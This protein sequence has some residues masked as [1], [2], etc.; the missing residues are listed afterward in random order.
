MLICA[1]KKFVCKDWLENNK[2]IIIIDTKT[3][4][5]TSY[6]CFIVDNPLLNCKI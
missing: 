6:Q 2:S 5:C 1:Q 3:L 4:H